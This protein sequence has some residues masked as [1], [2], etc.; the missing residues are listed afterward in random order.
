MVGPLQ[1]TLDLYGIRK[2]E[3]VIPYYTYNQMLLC[4]VFVLPLSI[5][6]CVYLMTKPV[7]LNILNIEYWPVLGINITSQGQTQT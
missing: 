2:R 1:K 4:S 5:C 3:R 6:T 7:L